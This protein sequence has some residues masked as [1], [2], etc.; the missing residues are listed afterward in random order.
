[1]FWESLLRSQ[2]QLQQAMY[3]VQKISTWQE[4]NFS[5]Y[6]WQITSIKDLG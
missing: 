5:A 6:Q 2:Q 3:P 4:S 1:M